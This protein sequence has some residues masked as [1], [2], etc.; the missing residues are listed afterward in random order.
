MMRNKIGF[1]GGCY[2]C[3]EAIFQALKG[4]RSVEQGWIAAQAPYDAFSEAVIVHFDA[5]I[6]LNQLV[7]I[8]LASHSSTSAHIM[9]NK[10]RSAVYYLN[11]GDQQAVEAIIDEL[12]WK[13]RTH[14]I[15]QVLPLVDF[16]LNKESYQNYYGQNSEKPFCK[17]YI[18]PKLSAIREQFG[19]QFRDDFEIGKNG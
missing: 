12:T 1:G 7:E 2:W 13:N 11:A 4:V 8:H 5:D 16:R 10:Y 19:L 18:D 9:R 6:T 3:T 17:T 14:Y 15:T